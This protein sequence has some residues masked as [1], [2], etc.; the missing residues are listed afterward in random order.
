MLSRLYD[1]NVMLAARS[2]IMLG[3]A[4]AKVSMTIYMAT[5]IYYY[6]I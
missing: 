4:F 1:N 5:Y 3:C 2:D 6:I